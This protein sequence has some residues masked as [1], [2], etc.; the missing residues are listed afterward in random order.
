VLP[1]ALTAAHRLA[2]EPEWRYQ[3]DFHA[4]A[5]V[6]PLVPGRSGAL[7]QRALELRAL[8]RWSFM[9]T[10]VGRN[11]LGDVEFLPGEGGEEGMAPD[12]VRQ[13][14]WFDKTSIRSGG[15]PDRLPYTVYDLPLTLPRP[16]G[17]PR[18]VR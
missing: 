11:N 3:V 10:I 12:L 15:E 14:L 4:D 9:H 17:Q 1:S 5:G 16:S 2:A 13:S 6:E 8:N 18:R 7:H